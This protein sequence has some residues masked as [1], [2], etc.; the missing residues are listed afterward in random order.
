MSRK[1]FSTDNDHLGIGAASLDVGDGVWVLAGG[2]VPF[3]LRPHHNN[4]RLLAEAYVHGIMHGE[5]VAGLA[6]SKSV[7][8]V[9]I[10]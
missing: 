1:L 5:A 8:P 2:S 3:L 7:Q 10:I 9:T 6:S 4:Y